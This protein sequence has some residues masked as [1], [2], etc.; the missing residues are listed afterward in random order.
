MGSNE[1]KLDTVSLCVGKGCCPT[2][3]F[4]SEGVTLDEDGAVL[5]VS[6][7]SLQLLFDEARKRGLVR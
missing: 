2:A 3:Q 1:S 6:Q 7:A 5:R 4:D